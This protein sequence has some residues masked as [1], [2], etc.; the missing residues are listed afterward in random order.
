MSTAVWIIFAVV[1]IVIAAILL[2]F[3]TKRRT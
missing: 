2:G 1:I 3:G